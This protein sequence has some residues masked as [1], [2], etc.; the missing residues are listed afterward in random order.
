MWPHMRWDHV[1]QVVAIMESL[2]QVTG[3]RVG[4]PMVLQPFQVMMILCWLGP[5]DPDTGLRLVKEG[6][7]TLARKNGKTSETAAL[8]TALLALHPEDYGL[9]GQEIQV[10]ASD[11][12]QAGIT[13]QMTSQYVARDVTLGIADKFK[14]T[15]SRKTLIHKSTLSQLRCLSSDA[16]RAHGGNPAL[17]LLDEIGNVPNDRAE[18]FYSVLTTGYGA[19]L[20]PLTLLLST[21]AAMDSHFFSQQ[22]DRGKRVNEG[23]LE[24]NTFAAFVFSLP[25]QD[26]NGV[27]FD[28][29]DEQ[30][31]YLAN[32]G[33]D[34]I[35]SRQDI[36]DW[37]RKARELPSLENNFRLLRMNQ[38]VSANSS[39]FTRTQWASC[40][41]H[42]DV[43]R[44]EGRR[45]WMG[46]DLSETTDLTSL[47]LVF[48]P[49]DDEPMPVLPFFWIPG[50]GLEER[51][52]RDKVPYSA[53]VKQGLIDATSA[54]KIDY[55]KIAAKIDECISKYD[56]GALG[57]DRYKM[58]Y[59]KKELEELGHYFEEKNDPFLREI[60]QGFIS[61]T[62]T[63]QLI[64]E[65][66]IDSTLAHAD[67]PIL[68]WNAAN[69]VVQR[70][71]AG[72]RKFSKK[73]SF[74]RIDG[75][76]AL[77]MAL[78]ARDEVRITDAGP[79]V[80]MDESRAVFM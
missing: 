44:L 49:E 63:V 77:G 53:W 38:R 67:H 52:K 25:E 21:Q 55:E 20:E 1:Y 37:A 54:R 58:K 9:D 73:D 79:S 3:G 70:D 74:G 68:K 51:G 47:V 32:P 12:E 24:D 34:T 4:R 36:R 23:M 11:R 61:A 28:P 43:E 39:L 64:E 78:H 7:Q 56:V 42:F 22:V 27:A 40:G 76:V 8:V 2:V 71:P 80:Y 59:V 60:G 75:I 46:L 26:E 33:I 57:F 69:T 15:P 72:N 66:V 30:W 31:W 10:G 6:L 14:A 18:E 13:F 16:Y 62:R 50:E 41:G 65:A 17:V 48:E 45:C 19:Q 29:Y 35:V 5:E